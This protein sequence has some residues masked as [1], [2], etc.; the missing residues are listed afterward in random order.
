MAIPAS[1][2]SKKLSR[3]FA[4]LIVIGLILTVFGCFGPYAKEADTAFDAG[5]SISQLKTTN[6]NSVNNGYSP[7]KGLGPLNFFANATFILGIV[8]VVWFVL[9]CILYIEN[10]ELIY[11]VLGGVTILFAILAFIFAC[12]VKSSINSVIAE[13]AEAGAAEAKS[14]VLGYGAYFLPAGGLL[15]G[16]GTLGLA[17][18]TPKVVPLHE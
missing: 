10:P 9:L 17:F 14:W 15:F 2:S 4:A 13:A 6:K 8:V 12:V 5:L 11:L 7:V 1:D 16:G 18:T 3:L